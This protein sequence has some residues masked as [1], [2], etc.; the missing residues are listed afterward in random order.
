VF[1]LQARLAFDGPFIAEWISHERFWL[2][3]SPNRRLPGNAGQG[4]LPVVQAQLPVNIRIQVI[5]A[6]GLLEKNF[7]KY[8]GELRG[9]FGSIG[10]NGRVVVAFDLAIQAFV[11]E[12]ACSTDASGIC[13]PRRLMSKAVL[14]LP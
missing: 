3:M 13:P 1:T 4:I 14:R 11:G 7:G 9:T 8:G 10:I 12:H 5:Q 2:I 6:F